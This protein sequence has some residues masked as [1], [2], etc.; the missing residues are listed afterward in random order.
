MKIWM[1]PFTPESIQQL[2]ILFE[3]TKVYVDS[4]LMKECSLF[5]NEV[6]MQDHRQRSKDRLT[7]LSDTAMDIVQPYLQEE[8]PEKWMFPSS[9]GKGGGY[10]TFILHLICKIQKEAASIG[11]PLSYRFPSFNP[12]YKAKKRCINGVSL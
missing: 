9:E 7:L 3:E 6:H 8:K 12:A 10:F 5:I 1:I 4:V 2:H 11:T